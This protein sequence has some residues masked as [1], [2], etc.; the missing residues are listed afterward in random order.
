M[1]S[2]PPP[3]SNTLTLNVVVEEEDTEGGGVES[4]LPS[5]EDS[6]VSTGCSQEGMDDRMVGSTGAET[7][8]GMSDSSLEIEMEEGLELGVVGCEGVGEQ[9][10]VQVEADSHVDGTCDD[11]DLGELRLQRPPASTNRRPLPRSGPAHD[12]R[13]YHR[14]GHHRRRSSFLIPFFNRRD[15]FTLSYVK[16]SLSALRRLHKRKGDMSGEEEGEEEEEEDEEGGGLMEPDT[17]EL[18]PG[19]KKVTFRKKAGR[20]LKNSFSDVKQ[21]LW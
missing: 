13:A 7:F 19:E 1:L 8:G 3:R 11:I 16:P 12:E 9:L 17:K 21:F 15:S 14:S 18:I 20:V 2:C 4:A 6:G 10:T 5:T